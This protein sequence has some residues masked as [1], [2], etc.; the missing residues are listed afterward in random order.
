MRGDSFAMPGLTCPGVLVP[1]SVS[2][3]R[4]K[5]ADF[6]QAVWT[7]ERRGTNYDFCGSTGY[8]PPEVR[9]L[10][11]HTDLTCVRRAVQ[12]KPAALVM[13]LT[14]PVWLTRH[15]IV[16]WLDVFCGKAARTYGESRT[17][18]DTWAAAAIV[19]QLL[20]GNWPCH[21]EQTPS[22]CFIY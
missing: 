15:G 10:T 7:W 17:S 2:A 12:C 20:S 18:A 21:Y 1:R 11:P 6:G 14:L 9:S 8:R 16:Q 4:V 13:A 3:G 22:Q 5:I 19:L